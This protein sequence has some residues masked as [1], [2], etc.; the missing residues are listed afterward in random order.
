MQTVEV[1]MVKATEIENW[2]A[3]AEEFMKKMVELIDR[4]IEARRTQDQNKK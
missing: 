2:Q 1:R 4:L 3:K